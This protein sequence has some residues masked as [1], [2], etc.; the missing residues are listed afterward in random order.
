MMQYDNRKWVEHFWVTKETI[1]QIREKFRPLIEKRNTKY[2]ASIPVS[3]RVACSFYKLSHGVEYFQ[4]NKLFA[5]NK[6]LMNMV[7]H[8]FVCV[9][10][11]IFKSQI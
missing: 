9:V 4:C 7:L 8:E 6:S 10:N 11:E 5:I 2:K 3:I 1:L